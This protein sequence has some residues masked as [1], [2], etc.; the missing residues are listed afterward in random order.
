MTARRKRHHQEQNV[1]LQRAKQVAEAVDE[2]EQVTEIQLSLV[3]RLSDGWRRVHE[4]NHLAH[5]F[6][7][8]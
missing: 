6:D 5:L 7:G 4:H 1:R 3:R 2:Q 8:R